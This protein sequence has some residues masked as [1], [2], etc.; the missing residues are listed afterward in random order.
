MAPK[1]TAKNSAQKRIMLIFMVLTSIALLSST[2]IFFVGMLPTIAA[3]LADKTRQ[4]SRVLTIGFMNFAACFPFWFKLMQ[5]GH[6]TDNAVAIITDPMT[7]II[8]YGGALVGYLIEWSLSGFVAGMMVQKGRRRLE[9]IK[10]TQEDM[11]ARWGKEVSGE[12]S[13]DINGF[14]IEAKEK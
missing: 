11:I 1:K 13:L 5:Q 14:P 7:I 12:V 3:R 4:R 9:T 2:I 8:M 10:K 6:K